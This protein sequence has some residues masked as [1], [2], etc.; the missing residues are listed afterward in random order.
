MGNDYHGAYP[1]SVQLIALFSIIEKL[2]KNERFI[3]FYTW[4]DSGRVERE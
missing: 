2:Y 4:L 3:D 1:Q